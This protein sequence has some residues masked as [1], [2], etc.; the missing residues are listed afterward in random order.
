MLVNGSLQREEQMLDIWNSSTG[1]EPV[2]GKT[3]SK[4]SIGCMGLSRGIID[5]WMISLVHFVTLLD[6]YSSVKDL[7]PSAAPK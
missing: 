4:G 1:V 7:A 5:S 6:T 2:I 3:M